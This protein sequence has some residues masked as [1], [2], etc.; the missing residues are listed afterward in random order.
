VQ[1]ALYVVSSRAMEGLSLFRDARDYETYLELLSQYQAQFGF[2]L[3]A[4]VLLPD[5]LHLC[6]EL[7][8]GTPL[9]TIMHAL[10]SR[11]TKRYCGRYGHT[12]HVFQERFKA[13]VAE[14]GPWLL[15]TTAYLH[16]LPAHA[17]L[18][19]ETTLATYRWSSYP[20]YLE[21]TTAVGP[22]L[23]DEVAEVKEL[24]ARERSD[25]AYEFYVQDMP[26]QEWEEVRQA[27]ASPIVGSPEFVE[28]LRHQ[29][30]SLQQVEGGR[31]KME[32]NAVPSTFDLRPSTSDL[33]PSASSAPSPK[34]SWRRLTV[35]ATSLAAVVIGVYAVG[36][37]SVRRHTRLL[38][39][40]YQRLL[41]GGRGGLLP[42]V[43]SAHLTSIRP[44]GLAGTVWDVQVRSLD[45]TQGSFK[46]RLQFQQGR[47]V[48]GGTP[49]GAAF[50][51]TLTPQ[52]EGGAVWEM[53]QA[54]QGGAL[55]SW[56]GTWRGGE[57]MVGVVV[58]QEPGQ[59]QVTLE[60]IGYSHLADGAVRDTAREL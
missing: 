37:L 40:H 19:D 45:G 52:S 24:L 47:V 10:N 54:G 42:G 46:E 48:I 15:R 16:A 32:A 9:S 59:S 18:A 60:F 31:W 41:D 5:Q 51:Y 44:L 2:K 35:V 27:L 7:T 17:G 34:R 33:P 14:K 36:E 56:R 1:G 53:I 26:A 20:R 4:F 25:W 30:P 39:S 6:L 13:T 50:R 55:L 11:Y 49:D 3:F 21:A 28:A 29:S 8:N 22:V 43:A 23:L 58:R 57:T 38:A 12:G